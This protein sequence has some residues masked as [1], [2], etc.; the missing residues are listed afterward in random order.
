MPDEKLPDRIK[1]NILDLH[2]N[3]YLQYYNTAIIIFFTY[4]IG[5]AIAFITKQ[6]DYKNLNQL[7]SVG[8]VTIS[9]VSII[10]TLMLKFK[11]HLINI[12][13]EIKKLR[14]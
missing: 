4:C 10:I 1:K 9:F 2:Y 13:E 12:L 6:I 14:F 3:K 7:L 11:K 5:I 8:F